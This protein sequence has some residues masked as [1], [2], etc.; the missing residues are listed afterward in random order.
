MLLRDIAALC[1]ALGVR[2]SALVARAESIAEGAG[3]R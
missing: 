2:A 3:E 1:A